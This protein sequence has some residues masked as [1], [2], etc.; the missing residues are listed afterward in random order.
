MDTHERLRQLINERGGLSIGWQR[1]AAYPSPRLRIFIGGIQSPQNSLTC[2]H[3]QRC[4]AMHPRFPD[5]SSVPACQPDVH[6]TF[7]Q[8]HNPPMFNR[9]F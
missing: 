5:G 2:R 4:A 9:Q 3:I 1:T 6:A 8:K 7:V